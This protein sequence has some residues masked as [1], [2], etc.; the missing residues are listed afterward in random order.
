MGRY[1]FPLSIAAAAVLAGCA[2]PEA[3][4][5]MRHVDYVLV[6]PSAVAGGSAQPALPPSYSLP[7]GGRIDAV[8]AAPRDGGSMWR[9]TVRMDDGSVRIVDTLTDGVMVGKR[10]NLD[11]DGRLTLVEREPVAAVPAASAVAAATGGTA[12]PAY[13][14]RWVLPRSGLGR[15]E[16]LEV[17]P[18]HAGFTGTEPI[19]S[20]WRIGVR[21]DDGTLQVVDSP[22][23]GLSVGKRVQIT[24]AGNIARAE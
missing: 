7:G 2:S 4:T 5:T 17:V 21:M 11:A 16:T 22:A 8:A 6:E 20:V 9:V 19:L 10:V 12:Q 3:V 18:N 14:T 1:A 23:S 24:S 15:I 13:E